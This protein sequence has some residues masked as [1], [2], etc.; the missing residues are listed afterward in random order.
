M[1]IKE[2]NDRRNR[3]MVSVGSIAECDLRIFQIVKDIIYGCNRNS[4]IT[5]NE[6]IVFIECFTKDRTNITP[7]PVMNNTR[8]RIMDVM[9]DLSDLITFDLGGKGITY[10][11]AIFSDIEL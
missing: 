11:A 8:S 2:R 1:P 4:G 5:G 10:R 7:C 6:G 3:H 9:I